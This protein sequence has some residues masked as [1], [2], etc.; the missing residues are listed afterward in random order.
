[1]SYSEKYMNLVRKKSPNEPEFHQAVQEVMD[2]I[3]VVMERHP[4]YRKAKIVERIISENN[5]LWSD[6]TAYADHY[7]DRF[8]LRNVGK[9][10]A[11]NPDDHL[12][13]IAKSDNWPIEIF[14]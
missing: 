9:P 14:D 1:M 3:E 12:K 13:Q 7:L 6:I 11:V 8:L 2:S 5:L 4:E 10:I